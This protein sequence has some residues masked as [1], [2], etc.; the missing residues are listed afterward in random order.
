M[1]VVFAKDSIEQ[2]DNKKL[3]TLVLIF[4]NFLWKTPQ[5]FEN[6]EI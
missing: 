2:F 5:V 3:K 6:P 1:V 4:E